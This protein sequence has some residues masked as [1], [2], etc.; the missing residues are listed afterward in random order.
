MRT[1][2]QY[3]YLILLGALFGMLIGIGVNPETR[4]FLILALALFVIAAALY[5]LLRRRE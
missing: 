2:V 1:F 4:R 3:L 5:M